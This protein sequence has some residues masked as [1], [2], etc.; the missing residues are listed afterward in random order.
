MKTIIIGA[1]KVGFSIA[2]MLSYAN[3]DVV[4]IEN[5]SERKQIV[6]ENLDVQTILGSGGSISIL[7]EAGICDAQLLV[8]VTE[9]DELNMVACLLGK[10]LGVKK[11]VARV[12]NPEYVDNNQ[13]SADALGIDLVINPEKVTAEMIG[14]LAE[15]PEAINVDYYA[16][17]KVQMVEIQLTKDSPVAYK[18]LMDIKFPKPNLIVAI[19]RNEKMIIPRG[20][21]QLKPN[22]LVFV[23]AETTNMV[24]IEKVL[25][26]ERVK[27]ENVTILGGGRIGFY[28]AKLLEKK[29]Y[30]VKLIEK[31]IEVCKE[32]S[33]KLSNTLVLQGDGSDIS[34]LE[35]EEVGQA[36]FFVAVTNDDKVN[37]LVSIIAKHL[38]AKRT[39]AQIRRTE[40]V[41]LVEKVGID[42]AVSPRLLTA[43][44]ILRFIR[45]GDIVSVS[46]IGG[47]KAEMIELIAQSHSRVTGKQ[48]KDLNFPKDA[49]I[50]AVVRGD[51]V[52]VPTG[53]DIIN[54]HDRVIVFALPKAIAKVEEF[55]LQK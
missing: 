20:H 31:N 10:K 5:N 16:D 15:V 45:K 6:E 12:R 23:L 54:P 51:N 43:G 41:P 49:I 24:A 32:I 7:H 1:G 25:G 36:D 28:L 11:T 48:L 53:K 8:A 19:L 30:T 14:K 34:L 22:D 17:G 50:G 3:H 9:Y 13:I 29:G 2:Q 52:I 40:Y 39:I 21:D 27:T 4:V 33:Q 37:L 38:G 42:V 26:K 18:R 55:F 46:L 35:E 44:A 47:A